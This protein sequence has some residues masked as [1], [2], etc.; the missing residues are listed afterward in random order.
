MRS[1]G[2][3]IEHPQLPLANLLTGR[4]SI[5]TRRTGNVAGLK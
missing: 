1:D 4:M 3:D 2:L 5:G